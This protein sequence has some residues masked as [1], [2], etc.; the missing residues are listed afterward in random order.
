VYPG[1]IRSVRVVGNQSKTLRTLRGTAPCQWRGHVSTI[2]G[3]QNG[4]CSPFGE[5]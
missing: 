3:I 5:S 1:P 2:A 4:D